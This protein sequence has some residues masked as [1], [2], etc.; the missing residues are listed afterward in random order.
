MRPRVWMTDPVGM[1][2]MLLLL[3]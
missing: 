2:I 3:F 1:S